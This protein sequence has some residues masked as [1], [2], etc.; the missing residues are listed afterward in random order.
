[1]QFQEWPLKIFKN[2]TVP[3][4]AVNANQGL[5]SEVPYWWFHVS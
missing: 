2:K 3:T 4:L 5:I 1:M